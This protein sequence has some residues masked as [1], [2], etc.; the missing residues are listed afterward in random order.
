MRSTPKNPMQIPHNQERAKTSILCQEERM[1]I[2]KH[3]NIEGNFSHNDIGK[4]T[5]LEGLPMVLLTFNKRNPSPNSNPTIKL[6]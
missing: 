4:V 1:E 5:R 2:N 3:A 6:M